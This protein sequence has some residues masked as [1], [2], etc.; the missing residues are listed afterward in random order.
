MFSLRAEQKNLALH[1]DWD[2]EVP[3]YVLMDEGKLRQV[4]SNLLGN[5]VKFTEVGEVSLRV[6]CSSHSKEKVRLIFDVEDSGPGIAPEEL[7]LIFEPFVQ[8]STG[9]SF[10]EGTG[11]GLSI[12][13]QY[14]KL[15]GGDITVYSKPGEGSGFQFNVLIK[16]TGAAELEKE[17]PPLRVLGLEPDQPEY[18]LLIA[19]MNRQLL[20]KLLEPLGFKIKEA[21][22]GQEAVQIWQDWAPHLIWMDM[23]MPIMD[24]HQATRQIKASSKG[25]ATVIIALTASAFE[26]E[27]EKVQLEGCDD[28]VRK[29]FREE[30]IFDILAK[31]LGVRFNYETVELPP[32]SFDFSDA[33][34]DVQLTGA[35]AELPASMLVD[36]RAATIEAD[37]NRILE[38][39]DQMALQNPALAGLLAELA[40]NFEYKR[41]LMV[42]D[43]A[44]ESV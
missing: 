14:A 13:R 18:R 16:P 12:S 19:E 25:Q 41:L 39:I 30:E 3:R 35:L 37:L 22:N 7:A 43:K 21:A 36:L 26:E 44:G 40:R 31:H 4:L 33:R 20:V 29:P 10:Q 32:G 6:T 8:T 11:L 9:R 23:R 5:A 27:R 42:I 2:E 1:F 24:G 38:L 34:Q 15:M 28:F 17:K